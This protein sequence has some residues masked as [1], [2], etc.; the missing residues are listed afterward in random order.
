MMRIES[1]YIQ[2]GSQSHCQEA[3]RL[4]VKDLPSLQRPV[5]SA[6]A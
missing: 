4:G 2:K 1:R 6:V 5:E 3:K